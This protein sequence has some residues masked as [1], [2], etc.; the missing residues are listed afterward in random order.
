M[1]MFVTKTALAASVALA[2][3]VAAEAAYAQPPRHLA[4]PQAYDTEANPDYGFG[5]RVAV[6]PDDVVTG[7]RVIGRDPDPF[8]RDQLLQEYDSRRGE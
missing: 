4:V 1:K 7:N 8:I 5:P 3:L 6:Q 2:A